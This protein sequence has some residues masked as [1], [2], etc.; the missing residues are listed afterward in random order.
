MSG[1]P[2]CD[3]QEWIWWGSMSQYPERI[4][5]QYGGQLRKHMYLLA[6]GLVVFRL[7]YHLGILETIFNDPLVHGTHEAGYL[8]LFDIV[9]PEPLCLRS[10]SAF[11]CGGFVR[12]Y[13]LQ[14]Y[15][16]YWMI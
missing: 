1:L 10:P 16:M 6:K 14:W 15:A 2:I 13:P 5:F 9:T 4:G 12:V 8:P 3:V 11:W 7:V